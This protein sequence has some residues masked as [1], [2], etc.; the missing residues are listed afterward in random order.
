MTMLILRSTPIDHQLPSPAEMLNAWKIRANLPVKIANKHPDKSTITNRLYERQMQQKRYHDQKA[1]VPLAPRIRGQCIRTQHPVTG[2]WNPA[3]VE[4]VR[5]EPRSYDVRAANG[6]ILHRNRVQL[7]ESHEIRDADVDP[8]LHPGDM[9]SAATVE[10]VE[11]LDDPSVATVEPVEHLDEAHDTN[12]R[13]CFYPSGLGY[14]T[15]SGRL[16]KPPTKYI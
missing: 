4:S 12:K 10:P 14:H 1:N 16:S 9:P 11:Y 13:V 6:G 5:P 8:A 7:R 2:K 3:T 15:R